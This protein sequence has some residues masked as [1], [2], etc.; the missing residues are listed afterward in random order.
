MIDA[1]VLAGSPN[2]GLLKECSSAKFEAL[3]PIGSRAMV[4]YVIDA[5]AKSKNI[6]NIVVVGPEELSDYLSFNNVKVIKSQNDLIKNI[7][8]GF[9]NLTDAERVL[10][11]T[12]DIPFVTTEIVDNFIGLCGKC[13]KDLYFP[14]VPK[15][16]VKRRFPQVERTFVKLK[17][18]TY[19]GGNIF[20]VNPLVVPKSLRNGQRFI[21]M[22]K[23]PLKLCRLLGASFVFKFLTRRLTLRQAE[24]KV[25]ELLGIKGQAVVCTFPEVGVDIDKPSDLSLAVQTMR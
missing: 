16:A 8:L 25:S 24:Q 1:L 5:L 9:K 18:G 2:N 13:E 20:L 15:E 21:E 11:A 22:R 14:V 17:D 3:I 12:S 19:T 6:R 23:S 7:S 10:V 4:E